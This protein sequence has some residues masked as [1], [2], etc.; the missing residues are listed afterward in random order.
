M[1][2]ERVKMKLL[3]PILA[4]FPKWAQK[5][6]KLKAPEAYSGLVP[7]VGTERI[8]VKLLRP[9]LAWFQEWAQKG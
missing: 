5:G 7:E 4:W 9:I 2:T 6:S 8:K 3:R 1:R